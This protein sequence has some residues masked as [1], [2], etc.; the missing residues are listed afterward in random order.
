[1]DPEVKQFSK[2]S[3][4]KHP[5][6]PLTKTLIVAL[7]K[8]MYM[9]CRSSRLVVVGILVLSCWVIITMVVISEFLHR[10]GDTTTTATKESV[11]NRIMGAP[12]SN[13]ITI[14]TTNISVVLDQG[15]TNTFPPLASLLDRF[16]SRTVKVQTSVTEDNNREY[17]LSDWKQKINSPC[18][19]ASRENNNNK[20][21]PHCFS[22]VPSHQSKND[23][24][25][26]SPPISSTNKTMCLTSEAYGPRVDFLQRGRNFE[27]V[28]LWIQSSSIRPHRLNLALVAAAFDD[29][30]WIVSRLENLQNNTIVTHSKE[31]EATYKPVQYLHD[32]LT[33]VFTVVSPQQES[34]IPFWVQLQEVIVSGSIPIVID[35]S[36]T[37]TTTTAYIDCNHRWL[38]DTS[39][40][41]ILR[42]SSIENLQS[43]LETLWNESPQRWNERQ[44]Q[45]RNSYLTYLTTMVSRAVSV[46]QFLLEETSSSSSSIRKQTALERMERLPEFLTQRT[47]DPFPYCLR[48]P[49]YGRTN[50]K[51]IQVGKLLKI[52]HNE[53]KGRALGLDRRWSNWYR[54]HFDHRPDVL[55]DYYPHG[56]CQKTYTAEE[57]F[58]IPDWDL[59][60]LSNLLPAKTYQDAAEAIIRRWPHGDTYISVHR[61]DLEGSCHAHAR[62]SDVDLVNLTC[63]QE[64][65]PKEQ[66]SVD[67]RLQACNMEY[68]LVPNPEGL[69]VVLFTDGQVPALDATFPHK[70]NATDFFVE[71]WLMVKSK[72][73]WGNPRSTVD[74]V[75]QHWRQ[76][77]G[78][79]PNECY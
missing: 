26:K 74:M 48:P 14:T 35:N 5:I 20:G 23:W 24:I 36:T 57:A 73:H 70:F 66:C 12:F 30:H 1:L 7:S 32:L 41:P 58:S 52:T 15:I 16:G 4:E 55:L 67:L 53:G 22:I 43:L 8:K 78:M 60:Y 63:Y 34:K 50:N 37:T 46:E 61:R 40:S 10:Q 17:S 68:K 64:R 47:Y 62:C 21:P 19:W 38:L 25:L 79:E 51:V 6:V 9:K 69:P 27:N 39:I 44:S 3:D 29:Y 42:T 11:M 33:S 71:M 56:E 75:V 2:W 31:E 18:I 49:F 13:T 54:Q 76:R 65:D 28:G 45:L 59:S 77:K 72:T